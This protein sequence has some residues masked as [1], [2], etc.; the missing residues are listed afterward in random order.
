LAFLQVVGIIV[1]VLVDSKYSITVS[2]KEQ[3]E[4]PKENKA[5]A[6]KT[7]NYFT[8]NRAS[9][10]ASNFNSLTSSAIDRSLLKDSIDNNSNNNLARSVNN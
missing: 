3:S 4:K 1:F 2:N 8:F 10:D 6:V 9:A 7:K 5:A